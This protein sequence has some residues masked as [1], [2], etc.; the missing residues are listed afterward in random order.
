[1][2]SNENN[3]FQKT[4]LEQDLKNNVPNQHLN[5]QKI[6]YQIIHFFQNT[7]KGHFVLG[8]LKYLPGFI[9]DNDNMYT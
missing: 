7:I 3:Y 5:F 8:G 2:Y 4:D 6:K 1:M 9:N